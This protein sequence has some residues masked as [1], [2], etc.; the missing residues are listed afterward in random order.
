MKKLLSVVLAAIM[1]LSVCSVA[2]AANNGPCPVDEEW[3]YSPAFISLWVD[4]G[5]DEGAGYGIYS[6]GK[7]V[8]EVAG[9]TYDTATNTLTLDNFNDPTASLTLNAMG[10]DFT[11]EVV[12]E[13]AIGHIT[14]WGWFWEGSVTFDGSGT[15]NINEDGEYYIPIVIQGEG[16]DS[17]INFGESV[18]VNI[19]APEEPDPDDEYYQVNE[20]TPTLVYGNGLITDSEE[21]FITVANGMEIEGIT[22]E[23]D[24]YEGTV[25]AKGYLIESTDDEWRG[26]VCSKKDDPNGIYGFTTGLYGDGRIEYHVDK[27]VSV[28]SLGVY[29]PDETFVEQYKNDWGDVVFSQAEF[30]E[31]GFEPVVIGQDFTERWFWKDDYNPVTVYMLTKADDPNGLYGIEEDTYQ[32]D[33]DNIQNSKFIGTI[34]KLK[35][36]NGEL[37]FDDASFTPITVGS[38]STCAKLPSGFSIVVS[39]EYDDLYL[40]GE[41][42]EYDY[43]TMYKDSKGK[44]YAVYEHYYNGEEIKEV[45]DITPITGMDGVYILAVN[46]T[47]DVNTLEEETFIEPTG[48][49]NKILYG[50]S[51]SYEGDGQ[52]TPPA[53]KFPD[54]KSGSWYFDAVNY[55]AQKGFI[56]GYS[57]GNFGPA[58]N[59]KRQDFVMIL[60]R[61]AGADLDKYAN[62]TPKFSDVKKGAYYYSAVMWAVDNGIIGG[63]SNGKFGVGDN[64]TREQVA[65]I[66]YRY[67][68]S[69][70]VQNVDSTLSKF[71]DVKK[72]SA[73]A[74]IPIAWAVQNGVISGMADGRVAP[75]EGASRA[76]I[77]MIVMRMDEQGMFKKS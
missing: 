23:D 68:G 5:T 53:P 32:K 55:C 69:P 75:V 47:V 70:D 54:V 49:F 46:T 7:L 76:Q 1:M 52:S 48:A 34:H 39:D 72:I 28:E 56:G 26:Y 61:I 41:V 18:T 29:L 8:D 27:Y 22:V 57:N 44:E 4:D 73:Y 43:L 63:Y 59:L 24:F 64:I 33:D 38:G 19:Y 74:K 50:T 40:A 77:A 2:F 10:E 31:M 35:E 60:A 9:V 30:E 17:G 58:D 6:A 16:T 21:T 3:G 14:T 67:A 11:V 20:Y 42:C 65:T 25:Q 71:S 36:K 51:F 13:C 45:Y 12:G 66:L 37:S 62:A 15:L